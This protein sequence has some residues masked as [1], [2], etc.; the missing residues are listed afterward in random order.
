[1]KKNSI[2]IT[3]A[4]VVAIAAFFGGMKYGES[5]SSAQKTGANYGQQGQG[6]RFGA[7]TNGNRQKGGNFTVGEILSMDDKSVTL[8]LQNG[9]SK[10]VLLSDKTQIMKS[11][12][13]SKTDLKNGL[14]LMIIGATNSDGSV[15]ADTIQ[16]RPATTK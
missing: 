11:V 13:G 8:K 15:T 6:G 16:I 14:N 9:G 5:Q 1:M 2:V 10:I 4:V 12:E 3:V 7:G